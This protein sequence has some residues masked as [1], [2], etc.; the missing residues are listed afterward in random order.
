MTQHR[1][2][3]IAGAGIAGLATA[4]GLHR[5]GWEVLVIERSPGRRSGGYLVNINGFGYDA[6]EKLGLLPALKARDIGWF[7]TILVRADGSAKFTVPAEIAQAAVGSRMVSV[8]RGDVETALYEKVSTLLPIRFGTVVE[9]VEQR[10]DGVRVRLSDG[11]DELADLLVGADGLHSGVR[12]LVFG[13]AD[14]VRDLGYLVCAFPLDRVPDELPE[15]TGTTFIGPGRMAAVINV[16]PQRSSTFFAYHSTDPRAEAARGPAAALGAVFGDLGGGV[17][18]ALKQL[19]SDSS[20]VY[21][22]SV[23]QVVSDRWSRGRVVLVGDAAWCVTPFGG[24]GVALALAGADRLGDALGRGDGDIAAALADWESGL[25][26]EVRK[27]QAMARKG[28]ARFVPPSR[29]HVAMN[30][31]SM[32]AIGL[33]GIR[34]VLRRAI[35]RANR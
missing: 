17:G 16:G 1:R 9:A 26:A 24:Y 7:T 23:S 2:A 25:R 31:A 19:E 10:A 30:E 29:F 21:F 3:I 27:R 11:G 35:A 28:A 22:D 13:D 33:P 32:R 5:A 18:D 12:R 34:S 6:A 8:F 20:P 15:S 14:P 4:L